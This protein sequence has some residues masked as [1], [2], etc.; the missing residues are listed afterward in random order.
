M[1]HK[2]GQ[3]MMI[4]GMIHQEGV[5]V[6]NRYAYY[7]RAPKYTRQLLTKLQKETDSNTLKSRGP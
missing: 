7:I 2:Y 5:T 3:Y 1:R 6:N 4:K